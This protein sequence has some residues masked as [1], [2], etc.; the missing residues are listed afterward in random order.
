MDL[1]LGRGTAPGKTLGSVVM[2][3]SSFRTPRERSYANAV[4]V[5]A[6]SLIT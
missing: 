1:N 4:T 6:I 5:E 3:C 2:V